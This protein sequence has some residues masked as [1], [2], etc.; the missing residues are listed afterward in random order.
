MNDADPGSDPAEQRERFTA[1]LE[2]A[3]V[4]PRRFIDVRDGEKGT[5]TAGH[6]QPINWLAPDADEL[7]GNY[8]VH[9]GYGL[10]EFDVDDY[11][12]EHDTEAL[13]ALPKTF[14]V[15]SPHTADDAP[16]HRYYAVED[17][18]DVKEVLEDVA[19]TLNPEPSWGEIKYDGKYVVGPGSQLDG[20]TKEWCNECEKPDGGYYRIAEDVPIATLSAEEIAEV[21]RADPEFSEEEEQKASDVFDLP[22][23]D[24]G[25]GG[26]EEWLTEADIREA[27]E[28][29]DPDVDRP[30]WVRIGYALGG[31]FDDSTALDLFEEWSRGGSKWDAD[32]KRD[33][34]DIIDDADPGGD[35]TIATVVE[36]AKRGGWDL[37]TCPSAEAGRA[38]RLKEATDGGTVAESAWDGD[39]PVGNPD[40]LPTLTEVI[41]DDADEWFDKESQT[42]TVH[43]VADHDLDDLTDRFE[44]GNIPDSIV[45][46][47]LVSDDLD[48]DGEDAFKSWRTNP[49]D[50]TVEIAEIVTDPWSGV[51]QGF[52]ADTKET[53][54][55]MKDQSFHA[56]AGQLLD[57]RDI[58]QTKEGETILVYDEDRGFYRRDGAEADLETHL[59]SKLDYAFSPAR[60]NRII[61]TACTRRREF[62]DDLGGPDREVVVANGVLDI[63]EP[64]D[65]DLHPHTP[66]KWFTAG[67]P[68]EYDPDAECSRFR[69][70]VD[71]AV[72]DDD[73]AKL[74]EYLGY[75]L[76]VG[77]QPFKKAMFL[78]GPTDSGKGT[79]LQ[80][81]E[82]LLGT[83][84]VANE[85]LHSLTD[86]RWGPH[87]L[88]GRIA[89]IRNEISRR[90]VKN[91]Q[92]FKEMTGGEDPIDAEDKGKS[93]YEFTVTQKF[94]FATNQFPEVESADDAFY[95][96]LLFA[97][98]PNRV[99]DSEKDPALDDKLEAELSGILNW[100]LE[101]LARLLN[102]G[103]FTDVRDQQTKESLV[104]QFGG[105]TERFAHACLDITGDDEDMVVKGDLHNLALTYANHSG[106]DERPTQ[107]KFTTEM[108]Q[109]EGVGDDKQRVAGESESVYTGI[110]VE[111]KA[112]AALDADVRYKN[113][114]GDHGRGSDPQTSLEQPD[115]SDNKDDGDG[116]QSD[117]SSNDPDGGA[118]VDESEDKGD[119]NISELARRQSYATIQE[120]IEELQT[121]DEPAAIDDVLEAIPHTEDRGRHVIQNMLDAGR[122]MHPNGDDEVVRIV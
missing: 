62:A 8:G 69:E 71:E 90:D 42:V 105:L 86:T 99:P 67:L 119:A 73:V 41:I 92:K 7:S 102:N 107:R 68:V 95:N 19:G 103:Q 44:D 65:P 78:V 50:W 91:P 59:E 38:K 45:A 63:T 20:C 85:T 110:R 61:R 76:L 94:W 28:H 98:F 54:G 57:E 23:E 47:I 97:S 112:L 46:D 14:T 13:D 25:D 87:S 113:S 117:E 111:P 3:S 84:N 66:E 101:G 60:A 70:F 43:P 1:R 108:K 4:S 115:G 72:E 48:G 21:L 2:A 100:A 56:A 104:E 118:D 51:I 64:D 35:A 88:F 120:T 106:V 53:R 29:I 77:E 34:P 39:Q 30:K 82:N 96:R 5:R 37:S 16:G 79:F 32:A 89:N 11:E 40:G 27:L 15:K 75:T 49:N 24:G 81:V 83:E 55:I 74:Q 122:L 31:F 58:L 18:G 10:I 9:P 33:A 109:I 80:V 12:D 93:K 17:D 22:P 121:D 36:L 26:D 52:Y 6:Q 114:D 116:E